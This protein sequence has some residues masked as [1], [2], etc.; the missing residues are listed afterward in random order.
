MKNLLIHW[1]LILFMLGWCPAAVSGMLYLIET[2]VNIF[3]FVGWFIP[4]AALTVLGAIWTFPTD[5]N[6][7]CRGDYE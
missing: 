1:P 5:R 3:T 2:H 7:L 4:F 6:Y